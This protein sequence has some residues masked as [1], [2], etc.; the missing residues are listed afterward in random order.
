[1]RKNN[2]Q[3]NN[4]CTVIVLMIFLIL[5]IWINRKTILETIDSVINPKKTSWVVFVD[6]S[7]SMLREESKIEVPDRKD[8]DKKEK[9]DLL[10]ASIDPTIQFLRSQKK[11]ES[12]NIYMYVNK[13]WKFDKNLNNT[14]GV[15]SD[16]FVKKVL[17]NNEVTSKDDILGRLEESYNMVANIYSKNPKTFEKTDQLIPFE[18]LY[19][20][21]KSLKEDEQ[22]SVLIITDGQYDSSSENFQKRIS[23]IAAKLKPEK[24]IKKITILGAVF[25]FA[26]GFEQTVTQ[27]GAEYKGGKIYDDN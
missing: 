6:V 5:G 26:D 12:W 7:G 20:N 3:N 10:Q 17:S 8:I 23:E 4:G 15:I 9:I 22:Y 11:G 13:D 21:I 27:I 16:T 2:N 19:Q 25:P 24:K 14:P 18:F 1:M